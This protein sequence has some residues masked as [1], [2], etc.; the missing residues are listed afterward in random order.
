MCDG[1]I[2]MRMRVAAG[3][4]LT[5]LPIL[6]MSGCADGS[7][8]I[9]GEARPAIEDWSTVAILTEMPEGADQIAVVKA[10]SDSGL[11]QQKSLDYAV[12]ELKKQV[13]KVGG[14][15]VVLGSRSTETQ[16]VG[17]PNYS[18]QGGTIITSSDTEVVQ[19]IAV[20]VEK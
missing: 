20:Y 19:G 4:F 5:V 16:V 13:A 3:L 6:S 18:T 9:L 15:A 14:N 1:V 11:T 8:L 7:A 2:V 12:A 10:S 17:I